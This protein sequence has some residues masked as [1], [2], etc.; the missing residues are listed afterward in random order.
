MYGGEDGTAIT[1]TNGGNVATSTIFDRIINLGKMVL[2]TGTVYQL[3]DVPCVKIKI[4]AWSTNAGDIWIGGITDQA[5]EV[6]VGLPLVAGARFEP[7]C[8]NSNFFSIT[9]DTDADNVSIVIFATAQAS[10]NPLTPANPASIDTTP[11]A[12]M[13]SIPLTGATFQS[14]NVLISFITNVPAD[15]STV[16]VTNI[17][18]SP[19]MSGYMVTV[20]SGNPLNI[21][22]LY[23]GLLTSSTLYTITVSNLV[24]VSGFPQSGSEQFHFTTGTTSGPPDPT[25]PTLS[26]FTPTPSGVTGVLTTIHPTLTFSLPIDPVSI[27]STSIELTNVDT[28]SFVTPLSYAQSVDQKTVTITPPALTGGVNYRLDVFNTPTAGNGIASVYGV[29]LDNTYSISFQTKLPYTIVYNVS[30]TGYINVGFF[31]G[32]AVEAGEFLDT[33]SALIGKVPLYFVFTIRKVGSPAGTVGFKWKRVPSHGG[34]GGDADFITIGTVSAATVPTTDTQYTFTMFSNTIPFQYQDYICI[35]F[36][37]GNA[38]NCIQ[39][40]WNNTSNVYDGT[41]TYYVEILY[42]ASGNIEVDYTGADY[43]FTL[44]VA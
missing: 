22:V 42:N 10:G 23:S 20:D 16:T 30:G 26:S 29:Y 28:T 24:S 17:T 14:K 2:R 38:S 41:K 9:P 19:S 13:S 36:E 6:G 21:L 44:G 33:G 25:P 4:Y 34:G 27:S 15:P 3:P 40:K 7:Y 31:S 18:A 1:V 35:E 32:G 43:A 5:P 12:I 39:T 37:S 11:P 8:T